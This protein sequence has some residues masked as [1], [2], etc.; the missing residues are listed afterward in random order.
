MGLTTIYKTITKIIRTNNG[1]WTDKNY[2]L[3][4]LLIFQHGYTTQDYLS[5][6]DE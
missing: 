2:F 3:N 4:Q 5:L 6:Q 1:I